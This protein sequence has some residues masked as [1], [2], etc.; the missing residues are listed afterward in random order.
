LDWPRVGY[1]LRPLANIIYAD[2]PVATLLM[3]STVRASLYDVIVLY[4]IHAYLV[5]AQQPDMVNLM[6]FGQTVMAYM[7]S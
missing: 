5:Y 6:C 7:L 3:L 2:Q 1:L 4:V